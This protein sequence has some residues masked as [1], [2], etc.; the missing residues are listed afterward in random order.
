M[1]QS[2]LKKIA[3]LSRCGGLLS[4]LAYER[5]RREGID[6][7]A[8]LRKT[9]L[10]LREV[11][12]SQIRLNLDAKKQIEFVDLVASETGDSLLGIHLA[13]SYDLREGGLFYYVMASAET[14]LDSLVQAARYMAVA[15]D[16][17]ALKIKMRDA[18]R[19]EVNYEGVARHT[20]IQQIE[21]WMASL[22]RVCWKLVGRK[23]KPIEIRFTHIRT[24]EV[25][26][27]K[28]LLDC[29]VEYGAKVDEIVFPKESAGCS[30]VMADTYLNRLCARFCEETIARFE[31]K[32][33]PL[34]V[35]V[36]NAIGEL[37]PH[38]R[39]TIESVADHLGVTSRTLARKLA[40]EGLSFGRVFQDLRLALAHRYLTETGLLVSEIAW[41][42]GYSE[43]ASFSNAF[44]RWT[45]TSPR[46]ERSKAHT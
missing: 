14:W 6:V 18:L 35:R 5:G 13:Y 17:V 12:D 9:R 2:T 45:G 21:F 25:A 11:K 28:K 32:S 16:G 20:D 39:I 43:V 24:K 38:Q 30:I 37:L 29:K 41:L 15:H 4:R 44:R 10:Q 3:A 36:Q 31:T 42:L 19:V 22:V 26:K 33:D 27:I 8:L 23:I 46:A 34:R 7:G 40:T 1:S